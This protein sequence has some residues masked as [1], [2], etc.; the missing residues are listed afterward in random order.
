MQSRPKPPSR[1]DCLIEVSSRLFASHGFEGTTVRRIAHECGITEAAIYK[2]FDNKE[3]LYEEAILSKTQRHLI[4]NDL[5]KKRGQGSI[6]DLLYVVSMHILETSREDPDLIR[7]MLYRSLEGFRGSTILYR[8]F[9]YPYIQF[10]REELNARM[11]E[12]EI[13]KVNSFITSRC[14][15][16]MVMDCA[17]NVELWNN[18][19]STTYSAEAVVKNN[20]PIFAQGL[21][22]ADSG[23]ATGE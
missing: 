13:R 10:L 16:G 19:E 1:R 12:G 15:V 17:L 8:E 6:E 21:L 9:R 3:H 23:P 4:K 14:F 5:E 22:P 7:I 2:H 11:A 20:V 18:L